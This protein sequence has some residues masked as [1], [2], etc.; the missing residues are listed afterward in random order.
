VVVLVPELRQVVEIAILERVE[1]SL[2]LL[3]RAADV[4]HDAVAVEA[5]GQ[6]GCTHHEGRV[7][8]RLRGP[9]NLATEGMRNHD[10]VGYFNCKHRIPQ[11]LSFAPG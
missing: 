5:F 9:K 11:F 7:M 4:D 6:K 10:L 8:Q 2:Q 1:R 3:V